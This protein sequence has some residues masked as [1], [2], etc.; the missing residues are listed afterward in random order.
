VV[1]KSVPPKEEGRAQFEAQK[2]RARDEA[3][4][5]RRIAELESS[6]AIAETELGLMREKLKED[7]GGDWTR[8]AELA[9]REQELSRRVDVMMT[10]WTKLSDEHP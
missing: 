3:K 5:K 4:K 9:E 8:L 10:E 2:A 7:H 6:I 1:V